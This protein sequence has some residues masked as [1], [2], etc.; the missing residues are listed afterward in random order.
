MNGEGIF[1]ESSDYMYVFHTMLLYFLVFHRLMAYSR[2]IRM[3][4]VNMSMKEF[5]YRNGYFQS[6]SEK[7]INAGLSDP[8]PIHSALLKEAMVE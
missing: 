7:A 2:K 5:P 4:P 1:I 3:F 6:R 8:T